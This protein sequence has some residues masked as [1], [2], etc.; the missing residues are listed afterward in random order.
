MFMLL[1]ITYQRKNTILDDQLPV[2]S[3]WNMMLQMFG[4]PYFIHLSFHESMSIL[5]N[6][7]V[8]FQSL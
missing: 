7:L 6:S 3:M 2:I 8:A 4:F 5:Y 1:V